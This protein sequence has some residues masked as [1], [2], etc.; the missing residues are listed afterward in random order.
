MHRSLP[1]A[2][3]SI[4]FQLSLGVWAVSSAF[5]CGGSS[6][7]NTDG[8]DGGAVVD[9]G[10]HPCVPDPCAALAGTQCLS[11][12]CVSG[13]LTVASSSSTET[14]V[15]TYAFVGESTRVAVL[16]YAR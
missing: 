8:K 6:G 7:G 11:G 15:G 12:R 3:R 1:R 2:R 10:Y 9:G 16:G 14:L 13:A 5:A 4:V